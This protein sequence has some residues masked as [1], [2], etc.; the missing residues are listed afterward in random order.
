MVVIGRT[1]DT[2]SGLSRQISHM[3]KK[4][5]RREAMA[6]AAAIAAA[7]AVPAAPGIAVPVASMGQLVHPQPEPELDA[8]C[9]G[10][11]RAASDA[12]RF[13]VGL[14]L[15]PEEIEALRAKTIYPGLRI[16][17]QIYS[18]ERY[19]RRGDKKD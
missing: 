14:R 3:N 8:I 2:F 6:G 4:L 7:V 12:A 13:L 18:P 11:M 19:L 17:R 1:H 16:A 5:N 9:W 15:T 10:R